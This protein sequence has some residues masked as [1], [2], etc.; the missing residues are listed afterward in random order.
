MVF[1]LSKSFIALFYVLAL[2]DIDIRVGHGCYIR[3]NKKTLMSHSCRVHLFLGACLIQQNSS[4]F[5][6]FFSSIIYIERY[7]IHNKTHW[8]TNFLSSVMWF[9]LV[10][11]LA[12]QK[13]KFHIS[14]STKVVT[15]PNLKLVTFKKKKRNKIS[16]FTLNKSCDWP[17]LETSPDDQ[18]KKE[19]ERKKKESVCGIDFPICHLS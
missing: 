10:L 4:S 1:S 7:V 15:D 6:W 2:N 12:H 14:H 19:K 9:I 13:I 8:T 18:K 11:Y 3:L 16:R 5:L 17:K